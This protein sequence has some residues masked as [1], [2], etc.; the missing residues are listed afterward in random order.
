[1]SGFIFPFFSR[2]SEIKRA[3]PAPT[4][5]KKMLARYWYKPSLI[6]LAVS[7]LLFVCVILSAI[8]PPMTPPITGIKPKRDN[9]LISEKISLEFK[10]LFSGRITLKSFCFS[11]D[12]FNFCL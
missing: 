5:H 7:F 10:F 6:L 11:N 2:F 8:I 9:L 12:F 3:V 4:L 1:M